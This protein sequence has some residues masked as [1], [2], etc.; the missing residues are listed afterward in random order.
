MGLRM[1]PR[2]ETG[3]WSSGSRIT[4]S[5]RRSRVNC[6]TRRI[7]GRRTGAQTS[8]TPGSKRHVNEQRSGGFGKTDCIEA[9]TAGSFARF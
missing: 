9:S 4:V 5:A 6:A 3:F 8:W 2:H 1:Q 7:A